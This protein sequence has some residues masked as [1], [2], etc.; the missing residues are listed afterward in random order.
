MLLARTLEDRIASLYRAGGKI[1]GGVYL[2]RGQEA[3]STALGCTLSKSRGDIFGGLIRD[4]SGRLAFGEPLLDPAR[5][6]LGS[7]EGPMRGRDGNIHRGRPEEGMPAMISHLGSLVSVVCGMLMARRLQSAPPCVGATCVGDGATSTGSFHEAMNLAAVEG[8]PLVVAVANN[9]YAY[10][11]PTEHQYACDHLVE[12]AQGYG[13]DGHVVDGTDLGAC[14]DT[15]QTAVSAALEQSEPQM[16]VG[17][18]LR[19]SGHGEH[20]DAWYVDAERRESSSGRDPIPAAK[21]QAIDAGWASEDEISKW[22]EDAS[23]RV[24]EAIAQAQ[25]EPGPNAHEENWEALATGRLVE[26]NAK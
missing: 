14:L 20:D 13:V 22:V 7:V 25:N 5:T 16:V 6:Y 8:L 18:L 9:Q 2:G 21:Q 15:F 26:G 24:S 4:M 17:K 10:S 19:L 3:F 12:R 11:T 23:K 1:V